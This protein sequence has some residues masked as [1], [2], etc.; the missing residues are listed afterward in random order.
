VSGGDEG[1]E[2][3]SCSPSTVM[4]EMFVSFRIQLHS[5]TFS[6]SLDVQVSSKDELTSMITS[7]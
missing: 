5:E 6:Y 4:L 7:V 1:S 3:I 2:I